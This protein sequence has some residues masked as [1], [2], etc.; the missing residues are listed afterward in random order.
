MIVDWDLTWIIRPIY[1]YATN[2][3]GHYE[4]KNPPAGYTKFVPG[5]PYKLRGT[6]FGPDHLDSSK[7]SCLYVDDGMMFRHTFTIVWWTKLTN[8][9]GTKVAFSKDKGDAEL[10]LN[11]GSENMFEVQVHNGKL[12]FVIRGPGTTWHTVTSS[13]AYVTTTNDWH[14]LATSIRYDGTTSTVKMYRDGN[15]AETIV[16]AG[17]QYVNDQTIFTG[18]SHFWLGTARV[19]DATHT[20]THENPM[21][22]WIYYVK[23]WQEQRSDT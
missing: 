6:W 20:R 11:D 9:T 18:T 23:I 19:Y 3:N 13:T 14:F 4:P 21:T 10:A 7:H 1:N 12:R 22:G 15:G 16:Y 8:T 17:N 2:R 5:I